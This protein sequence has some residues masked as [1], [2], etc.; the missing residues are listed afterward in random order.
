VVVDTTGLLLRVVIHPADIPERNGAELV[1][2]RIKQR[3][4]R[5]AHLWAD[6]GYA[7]EFKRWVE[8]RQGVELEVVY[9]CWR[10]VKRYLPEEYAKLD[11]GFKV[12]RRHRV[13]ERTFAWLGRSRRLLKDH[14]RL[15]DTSE[16]LVYTPMSRLML[17]PLAR[18][19]A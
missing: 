1:L 5:L 15:P 12:I 16:M 2:T 19:Y 13:V 9:P 18:A 10:Q 3:F 8:K 14:Q 6:Q 4:P 17:K 7:G 11:P